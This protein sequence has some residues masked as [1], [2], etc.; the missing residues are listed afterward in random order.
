MVCSNICLELSIGAFCKCIVIGTWRDQTLEPGYCLIYVLCSEP[1][2][3]DHLCRPPDLAALR[4]MH[5]AALYY[6]P[7]QLECI[8]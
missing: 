4:Q 5:V 7:C 2:W 6:L 1:E 8:K 3:F